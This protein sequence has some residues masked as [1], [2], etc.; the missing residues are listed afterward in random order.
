MI[1]CLCPLPTSLCDNLTFDPIDIEDRLS[2]FAGFKS[3]G[4]GKIHTHCA[5]SLS[6]PICLLCQKSVDSGV[7]PDIWKKANITPS[8]KSG[9]KLKLTNYR[10]ISLTS[11][12]CKFTERIIGEHIMKYL[13]KFN[14]ISPQQHGF[15]PKLSTVTNLLEHIDIIS[16]ALN[17]G[18]SVDVIYLDFAKAFDRVPHKRLVLKLASIG[19]TGSL[20]K[21][22]ESFLSNRQQRVVMGENISEWKDILSGVPQGSVLGPLFFLIY[23]NDLLQL[24]TTQSKVYAD[25]TKLISINKSDQHKFILQEDLNV[26]YRWTVDWLLFLNEGKCKIIYLGTKEQLLNKNKYF[27]NDIQVTETVAE[28]DLGVLVTNELDWE[29]QIIRNCSNATFAAKA[30][31]ESFTFKTIENIKYLYKTIIRPKLEY[32]NV[33]WS[34]VNKKYI[35]ML[36]RVQRRFTKLGPLTKLD[37]NERLIRL[38]LTS[39]E[40]RRIRGDL[41]QMFKYVKGF[42]KINFVTP[43]KFLKTVTRGH[44]FKYHGDDLN[45]KS[46]KSR[47]TYFLNRVKPYWNKL[48]AEALEATSINGFKNVIDKLKLFQPGYHKYSQDAVAAML[49]LMVV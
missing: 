35:N 16:G 40:I 2:R 47:S 8:F 38:G 24:L 25:D 28:K 46:H 18:F 13:Q 10:G 9:S 36:E 27:I 43:P 49:R 12:F 45:R 20:L 29:K 22:C 48:P 30:I 31:F 41:I 17:K 37:Y 44:M 33:I 7:V 3:I 4:P 11:V 15:M 23:L 42:D 6:I 5:L 14:L 1:I 26:I 21:W 19:I 34:P 32:A 39:L